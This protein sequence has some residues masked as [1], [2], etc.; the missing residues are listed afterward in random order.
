MK[1]SL[2]ISINS[3]DI[4][5]N[6][7]DKKCAPDAVYENGSCYDVKSIIKMAKKYN[8]YNKGNEIVLYGGSEMIDSRRY[9]KY[10]LYQL[11]NK[12][13]QCRSQACW[14]TQ[15]YMKELK[16]KPKVRPRGPDGRFEWL[17]TTNIEQTLHQ[18][19]EKHP[20]FKFL[21]AV[22]IDYDSEELPP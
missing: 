21:G 12:I 6:D 2:D 19:E 1:T 9:K 18:Y 3:E 11:K 20:E 8:E 5:Y 17:S 13:S 14:L 10:L 15:P 16:I 22:P 4:R 7:D